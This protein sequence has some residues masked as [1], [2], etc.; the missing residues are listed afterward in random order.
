MPSFEE[1]DSKEGSH[2][3]KKES[4]GEI[5]DEKVEADQGGCKRKEKGRKERHRSSA[6]RRCK[7]EYF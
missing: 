7:G 2:R 1:S 4:R 6:K 3:C 5:G